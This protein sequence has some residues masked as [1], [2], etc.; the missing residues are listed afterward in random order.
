M[1][2]SQALLSPQFTSCSCS[3]MLHI[4]IVHH[5]PLSHHY[6]FYVEMDS[7]F[8]ANPSYAVLCPKSNFLLDKASPFPPPN[9]LLPGYL[10]TSVWVNQEYHGHQKTCCF[11]SASCCNTLIITK[12]SSQD[13]CKTLLVNYTVWLRVFSSQRYRDL[14]PKNASNVQ[15]LRKV[16]EK[17]RN[18]NQWFV[19]NAY[20]DPFLILH[21]ILTLSLMRA[22]PWLW[23]W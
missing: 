6:K 14:C 19:G 16:R 20:P 21:F 12:S 15:K 5:G 22:F 4:K 18:T 17:D 1:L 11:S 8:D 13:K 10:Q 9:V 23:T 2:S 3:I 7:H